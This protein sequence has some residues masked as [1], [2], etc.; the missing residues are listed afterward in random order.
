MLYFGN[1]QIGLE[2]SSGGRAQNEVVCKNE[3][4]NFGRIRKTKAYIGGQPLQSP[5]QDQ[6]KDERKEWV[7]QYLEALYKNYH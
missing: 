7:A 1:I 6:V 3:C 2:S 4:R 5:V